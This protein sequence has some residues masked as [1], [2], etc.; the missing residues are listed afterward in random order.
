MP[1]ELL[2]DFTRYSTNYYQNVA[3]C[4]YAFV[5]NSMGYVFAKNW[6]NWMTSDYVIT[7]IKRSTSFLRHSV[8]AFEPNAPGMPV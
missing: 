1:Q 4:A 7:N 6:Q 3:G 2:L 8:Y 5:S